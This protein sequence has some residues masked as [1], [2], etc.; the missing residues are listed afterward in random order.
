MSG[1]IVVSPTAVRTARN[2]E[3]FKALL[4]K[5]SVDQ[6]IQYILCL[7]NNNRQ[8]LF[9]FKRN[10][11]NLISVFYDNLDRGLPAARDIK[12]IIVC[13][14]PKETRFV[15]VSLMKKLRYYFDNYSE[16]SATTI[17]IFSKAQER[18]E[19]TPDLIAELQ[20]EGVSPEFFLLAMKDFCYFSKF[21]K[22]HKYYP[23]PTVAEMAMQLLNDSVEL[24]DVNDS[25]VGIRF[26]K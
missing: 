17:G 2:T 22:G 16:V 4:D 20:K 6:S 18:I 8:F 24:G 19:M 5:A 7:L 25:G 23:I 26:V 9:G 12:D 10:S 13:S 15:D 21:E 11:T 1:S 14:M 3:A